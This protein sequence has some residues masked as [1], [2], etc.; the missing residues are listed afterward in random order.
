MR[1]PTVFKLIL[2]LILNFVLAILFHIKTI[3]PCLTVAYYN[4]GTTAA[5]YNP[6]TYRGYYYDSD[7]GLYYLNSR[8]Y[9]S[10]TGRFIGADG[11]LNDS[12]LGYNLF[13][14]CENNPVMYIDPTGEFA[15]TT[16]IIFNEFPLSSFSVLLAYFFI[17][18]ILW[19]KS[20]L[21]ITKVFNFFSLMPF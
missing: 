13:A 20:F 21:L 8:Y 16:A 19:L 2:Q 6:F 10:N 14:Y 12:L 11:Q 15:F 18:F 7:L 9:D 5:Q 1:S 3:W 4:G 17:C